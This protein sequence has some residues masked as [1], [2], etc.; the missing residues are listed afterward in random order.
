MQHWF[1][2][3]FFFL[4]VQKNK[5]SPSISSNIQGEGEHHEDG[6]PSQLQQLGQL[7]VLDPSNQ[8]MQQRLIFQWGETQSQRD[9]N[10]E[11]TSSVQ[12]SN[13]NVQEL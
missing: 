10:Q 9:C 13:R 12:V 4:S 8:R 7:E 3:D 11:G 2:R 6:L 5:K 1:A